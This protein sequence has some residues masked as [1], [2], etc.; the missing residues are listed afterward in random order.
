MAGGA[1]PRLFIHQG[2]KTMTALDTVRI[3][4]PNNDGDYIVINKS[5]LK[6][7]HKLFDPVTQ[8]KGTPK[9]V[10]NADALDKK[11]ID[12]NWF[13]VMGE[14]IV[15][16]PFTEDQIDLALENEKKL[17]AGPEKKTRDVL[18]AVEIPANWKEFKGP[19]LMAL[20]A[21]LTDDVVPN[22]QAA[23]AVVEAEV[24]L[25]LQEAS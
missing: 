12:G 15:S 8:A 9:Q 20:A 23:G 13:V 11:E 24:K 6:P 4:D 21:R 16:G 3:C 7:E 2:T 5:A 10:P 17:A 1:I 18:R 19:Q 14:K 25:R 22:K